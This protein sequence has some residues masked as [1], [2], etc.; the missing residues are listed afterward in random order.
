MLICLRACGAWCCVSVFFGN[1]ASRLRYFVGCNTFLCNGRRGNYGK[2]KAETAGKNKDFLTVGA[3]V[4]PRS[5]M[6][7][8]R[9]NMKGLKNV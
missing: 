2:I 8:S 3:E 5:L 1:L 4:A 6:M 9:N 7:A